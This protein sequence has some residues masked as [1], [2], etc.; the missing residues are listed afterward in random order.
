MQEILPLV[1]NHCKEFYLLLI[2]KLKLNQ[3]LGVQET[4]FETNLC[5]GCGFRRRYRW[6]FS[7]SSV[8]KRPMR[9]FHVG[10]VWG[11]RSRVTSKRW[12]QPDVTSRQVHCRDPALTIILDRG[13]EL[14]WRVRWRFAASS[15]VAAGAVDLK[16]SACFGIGS[17]LLSSPVKRKRNKKFARPDALLSCSLLLIMCLS[18]TCGAGPPLETDRCPYFSL[19]RGEKKMLARSCCGVKIIVSRS[20]KVS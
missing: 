4:A 14:G 7:D 12:H 1:C 2:Q 13:V 15:C 20:M 11:R 9:H 18:S 16:E 5:H 10:H 8:E 19:S 3:R 6:P 17:P